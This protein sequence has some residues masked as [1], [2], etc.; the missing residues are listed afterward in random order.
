MPHNPRSSLRLA[1]PGPSS[2]LSSSPGSGSIKRGVQPGEGA[3][4][5]VR[6]QH[7]HACDCAWCFCS[8]LRCARLAP[9]RQMPGRV[10]VLLLHPL[11]LRAKTV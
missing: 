5:E 3:V 7:L 11:V 2:S 9:P 6:A 4:R 8:L 10:S 1:S